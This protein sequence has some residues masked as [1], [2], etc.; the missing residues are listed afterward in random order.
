LNWGRILSSENLGSSTYHALQLEANQRLHRGLLFQASYTLARNVGNIGGDAPVG[1]TPEV[2]YGLAV[3]DRYHLD[4]NVGNIAAT[5]RH[6]ALLTAVYQLPLGESRALED[7]EMSTVTLI[8]SGPYLTP[9]ISPVYDAANV[10]ALV[11]GTVVRPDVV[12]DPGT[13]DASSGAMWN[14]NAFAPTP[15]DAARIGS[16]RVGSLVGPGTFTIAAG[17]ARTFG[18]G[19]G[20]KGRLEL[21]FTNLLNRINFAAPATDVTT[22]ATFGKPTSVQTA[23]NAGNRTGQVAFR[24][25]F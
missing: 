23:E 12:G 10:N 9:T 3:T 21:T 11:R 25:V 19:R 4:A 5:R 17:L 20:L 13:P 15:A 8:Q 18:V 7:W 2:I 24:L 16:A 22:P 1:F 6:R 14:I